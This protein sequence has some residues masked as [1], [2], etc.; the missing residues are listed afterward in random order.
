M[1]LRL[2]YEKCNR[3]RHV[4]SNLKEDRVELCYGD[5]KRNL[6]GGDAGAFLSRASTLS[7]HKVEISVNFLLQVHSFSRYHTDTTQMQ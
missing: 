5:F 7:F 3:S 1:I 6:L 2:R 4:K